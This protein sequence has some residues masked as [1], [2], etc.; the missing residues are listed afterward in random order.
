MGRVAN[1][2]L[3]RLIAAA[4]DK[5]GRIVEFPLEGLGSC[6]IP[7][8]L[9]LAFPLLP[10]LGFFGS[11]PRAKSPDGS[12]QNDPHGSQDESPGDHS[13][14]RT[15]GSLAFPLLLLLPLFLPDGPGGRG[16]GNV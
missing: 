8:G 11:L 5:D 7:E 15:G 4:L 1:L 6:I 12:P 13:P 16:R 9:L 3:I 14:D 10:L 2:A